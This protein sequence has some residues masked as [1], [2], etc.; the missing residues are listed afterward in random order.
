MH[1]DELHIASLVVHA[2]AQRVQA[3]AAEIA[4]MPQA[5][6]HA[7]SPQ[8]KLIVTLEAPSAGQITECMTRIQRL[9]GVFAATLVFQCVD[10]LEAM[11]AEWPDDGERRAP[12]APA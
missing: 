3:L 6:L 1:D 8:G 10:S 4:A 11:N 12:H 2:R 7:S 9:D 5:Q